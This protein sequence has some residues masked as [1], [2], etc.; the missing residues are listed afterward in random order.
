MHDTIKEDGI[1]P[2]PVNATGPSVSGTE[3]P[4]KDPSLPFV[5]KKKLRDIVRRKS[6]VEDWK[7]VGRVI[8]KIGSDVVQAAVP[9]VHKMV[10]GYVSAYK[11]KKKK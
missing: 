4:A 3:G 8:K 2:S 10:S 5:R 7:G 1:A 6:V 11:K 9:D